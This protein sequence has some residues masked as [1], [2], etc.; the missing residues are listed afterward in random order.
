M[1]SNPYGD[2]SDLPSWQTE[3][4]SLPNITTSG[5][6]TTD[7]NTLQTNYLSLMADDPDSG[8]LEAINEY[9][10]TGEENIRGLFGEDYKQFSAAAA[11]RKATEYQSQ[12]GM[13]KKI[14]KAGL[15]RSGSGLKAL[16]E[17]KDQYGADLT[18]LRTDIEAKRAQATADIVQQREDYVDELQSIYWNWLGEDPT[19]MEDFSP[20]Q[21]ACLVQGGSWNTSS[22]E[23]DY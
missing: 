10:P 14:G 5:L 13:T 2:W 7:L 19:R 20:D 16:S 17:L 9:D 3:D 11:T 4:P 12:L 23:C 18:G 21:T 1:P 8:W 6:A 22:L 15:A